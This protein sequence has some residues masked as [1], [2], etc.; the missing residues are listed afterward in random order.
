MSLWSETK[1]HTVKVGEYSCPV[2]LRH[3]GS[4]KEPFKFARMQADWSRKRDAARL[5]ARKQLIADHGSAEAAT[6]IVCGKMDGADFGTAVTLWLVTQESWTDIYSERV[7]ALIVEGTTGGMASLH[8]LFNA[9]GE[10]M[11]K[12]AAA[13]VVAFHT[14]GATLGES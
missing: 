7:Q 14:I 2:V 10:E 1:E 8:A 4:E 9:G 3:I 5:A 12:Q 13:D 6:E 11:I